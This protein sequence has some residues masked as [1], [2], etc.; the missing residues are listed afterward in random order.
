MFTINV[1]DIQLGVLGADGVAD[2]M[3]QVGLAEADAPVDEEGVVLPSGHARH[4]HAS[5]VRKL[6]RG[7]YYKGVE[8]IAG[9]EVTD[10]TPRRPALGAELLARGRGG[11]HQDVR[12]PRRVLGDDKRYIEFLTSILLKVTLYK[13][14][15][16]C[17]NILLEKSIRDPKYYFPVPNRL[18]LNRSE[19]DVE[20]LGLHVL[21]DRAYR[22]VPNL[23]HFVTFHFA[24]YRLSTGIS[25]KLSTTYPPLVERLRKITLSK[26]WHNR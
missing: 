5:G 24:I 10:E 4:G 18:T 14:E 8:T 17:D 6:I 11:G 23:K 15:V 1:K 16:V 9:V 22:F 13:I 2:G 12:T 25:P 19:P 20:I 21:L 7:T 26:I 3:D